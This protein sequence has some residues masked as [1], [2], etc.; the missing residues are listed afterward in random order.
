MP[1]K[2]C[3]PPPKGA[4]DVEYLDRHGEWRP[5]TGRVR[6]AR[7]WSYMLGGFPMAGY[8]R[9]PDDAWT[10]DSRFASNRTC[11][12]WGCSNSRRHRASPVRPIG[13]KR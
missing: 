7:A 8:W 4:T 1:S 5:W 13:R 10:P 12:R 2:L 9:P 11:A 3:V 6:A